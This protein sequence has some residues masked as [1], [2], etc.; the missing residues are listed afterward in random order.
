MATDLKI[1]YEKQALTADGGANGILAVTSTAKLR[2]DARVLLKSNT[3]DAV[4]LVIDAI[5]DDTH[6]AVRDP[7]KTGMAR[8]AADAYLLA[9]GAALTQNEQSD[10]YSAFWLRF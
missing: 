9:D 4:E 1:P 5:V 2:K 8:Y 6:V 3:V 10:F 7:S